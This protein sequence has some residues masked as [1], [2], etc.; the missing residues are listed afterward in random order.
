MTM[1]RLQRNGTTIHAIPASSGYFQACENIKKFW[2]GTENTRQGIGSVV[3][4]KIFI[5]WV[6]DNGNIW[7]Q[8]RE[9]ESD[10]MHTTLRE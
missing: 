9:L 4:D 6:D 7:T 1:L 5:T 10:R 3:G 8:I 2:A